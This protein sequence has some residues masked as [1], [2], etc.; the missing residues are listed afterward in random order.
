MCVQQST[1]G[2]CKGFKLFIILLTG[3]S[4]PS[5]TSAFMKA[6]MHCMMLTSLRI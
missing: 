2:A 6:V 5:K 1:K 4:S 3:L